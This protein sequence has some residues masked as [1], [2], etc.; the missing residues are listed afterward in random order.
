MRECV[1]DRACL[2][3]N[4]QSCAM[5]YA[6]TIRWP[7]VCS[8]LAHLPPTSTGI[9]C[10]QSQPPRAPLQGCVVCQENFGRVHWIGEIVSMIVHAMIVRI[11]NYE[12]VQVVKRLRSR[13]S[14]RRYCID[15]HAHHDRAHQQ[16][17]ER[18]CRLSGTEDSCSRFV[19][20]FVIEHIG[21]E[22]L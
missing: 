18:L 6:M 21:Q 12:V 19:R 5:I 9:R 8:I 2:H 13:A 4:V 15:S 16:T 17:T 11:N 10:C 14:K 1:R 3:E 22:D 7:C 20:R